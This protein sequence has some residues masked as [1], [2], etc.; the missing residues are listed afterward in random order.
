MILAALSCPVFTSCYD[1]TALNEA[2]NDVKQEVEAIKGSLAALENAAKAG[3]TIEEYKSI[4][5][6][7]ELTF[8]NGEKINIYSGRFLSREGTGLGPRL[9]DQCTV[10]SLRNT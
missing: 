6:G 7:Y 1:D 2:I 4:E 10:H 8:S 9:A 3:L 5:G